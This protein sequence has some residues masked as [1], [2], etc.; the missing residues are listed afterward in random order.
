MP[1][2][3]PV[4]RPATPS[5]NSVLVGL[6]LLDGLGGGE[7]VGARDRAGVVADAG[8]RLLQALHVGARRVVRERLGLDHAVLVGASS[9]AMARSGTLSVVGSSTTRR[10]SPRRRPRR[11]RRWA[12]DAG[13]TTTSRPTRER[14]H[15]PTGTRRAR[16][17]WPG[18]SSRADATRA[19]PPT[20]TRVQA[21]TIVRMQPLVV[22]GGAPRWC[23]VPED[24]AW[25]RRLQRFGPA[26]GWKWLGSRCVTPNPGA[27]R[28]AR[29]S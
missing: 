25:S 26:Y 29:E 16:R 15:R 1:R 14:R 20:P 5:T 2:A 7:V 28:A 18:L 13:A 12:A 27:P 8:Q 24:P 11:S 10:W 9:S 6:V 3:R 23:G 19:T 21:T 17:R 4:S 22:S